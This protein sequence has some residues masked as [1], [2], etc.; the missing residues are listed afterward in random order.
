MNYIIIFLIIRLLG[1]C[2][3]QCSSLLLS[4]NFFFYYFARYSTEYYKTSSMS[5]VCRALYAN[6]AAANAAAAPAAAKKDSLP[7]LV[8]FAKTDRRSLVQFPNCWDTAWPYPDDIIFSYITIYFFIIAHTIGKRRVHEYTKL[9]GVFIMVIILREQKLKKI[10][11]G[12][13]RDTQ[14]VR[15][16]GKA[17]LTAILVYFMADGKTG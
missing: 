2:F 3:G 16:N 9:D 13:T 14:D 15:M 6:P 7:D 12:Y 10:V 5:P 4:L 1:C 8:Y 11:Y 17:R